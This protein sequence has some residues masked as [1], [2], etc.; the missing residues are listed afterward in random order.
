MANPWFPPNGVS[1]LSPPRLSTGDSSNL[2]PPLPPD[3]PD[4]DLPPLSSASPKPSRASSQTA[5]SNRP[6]AKPSTSKT[7]AGSILSSPAPMLTSSSKPNASRSG[8]TVPLN[9]KI[10]QPKHSSPIQT[11][12]AS[13]SPHPTTNPPPNCSIPENSNSVQNHLPSKLVPP[14]SVPASTTNPISTPSNP[15]PSNSTAT[16]SVPEPVQNAPNPLPSNSPLLEKI[17]KQ[18]DKT[19]KRLAPVTLSENGVPRVLIPDSVF[20]IGAEIHKDFIICYFN[21]KPPPFNQIQ[22]VLNHM[23]GKG[24]RVEIHTNPLSRS[25]LVRIPSDYL[26]Q[27]ILEKSVWYVGESMFHAV[28]WTSSASA[29]PPSLESIQIWAHLTGVPL[30][31]RHQ[32]GLSLVAGLVGEP[33]ET[34]DFTK[35]FVSLT[36]SHVKVAVDLTKPLPSVVEFVRQS[37]EVVQVQVTYPW[38]PPTCSFCKELGHVSRNCLQAPPPPKST[39][40]PVKKSQKA[41]SASHKGINVAPSDVNLNPL[42]S[43]QP[44]KTRPSSSSSSEPQASAS[45]SPHIETPFP[46]KPSV[47]AATNIQKSLSPLL[48]SPLP[49]P[50]PLSSSQPS[51]IIPSKSQ[52][53]PDVFLTPSL[54]RP[55]PDPDQKPFPSFTAQLSYFSSIPSSSV[56]PLSLPPPFVNPFSNSFS[57]LDPDGSLHHEETID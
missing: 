19:L 31:L 54:K 12:R 45:V 33:K 9:F 26:R 41:Q 51:A 8:N 21:G 13:S 25:M 4:P 29:S 48:P 52:S 15:T 5:R 55:R 56:V 42:P 49:I 18:E 22:S 2:I 6:A 50:K 24:K 43:S 36:L 16:A 17:R 11:N 53:P 34:D 27:K 30:D 47:F 38:V 1:A 37:G 28:Q 7:V 46:P 35:N 40:D 10:L 32:Q 39:D 20:Q 3:P 23:W 57:V 44:E 14:S